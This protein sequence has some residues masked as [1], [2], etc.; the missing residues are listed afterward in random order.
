MQKQENQHNSD[1]LQKRK[2]GGSN[3]SQKQPISRSIT[4]EEEEAV[5][6]LYT[7][8][9]MFP[10]N[11]KTDK[12]GE[13]VGESS[14]SKPSTLPEARES[15]APTLDLVL[16]PGSSST[17]SLGTAIYGPSLHSSAKTQAWLDNATGTTGPSSFGNGVST[18][19]VS[20]V[21]VH[22]KQSWKRCAAQMFT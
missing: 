14:E 21:T 6:T 11:D 1:S 8:V 15:P 17:G 12:K 2:H 5:E 7:L 18:E 9:G 20:R 4:K 10:D 19:K 16:W 13:L 3:W 22:K